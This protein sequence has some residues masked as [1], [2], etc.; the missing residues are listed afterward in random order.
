MPEGAEE[1]RS[2]CMIG[3][4]LMQV[5]VYVPAAVRA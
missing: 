1:T 5:Q 4:V 2:R 3:Y